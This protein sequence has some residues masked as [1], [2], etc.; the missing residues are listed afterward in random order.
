MLWNIRTEP[1]RISP[2]R[3]S[4]TCGPCAFSVVDGS[5]RIMVWRMS[6]GDQS[7]SLAGDVPGDDPVLEA[8]CL[9]RR[10]PL[11]IPARTYGFHWSGVAG[12][13]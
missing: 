13:T 8:R 4:C 12:S 1:F 6:S 11:Q 2:V 9:E 5:Q 10:L 3:G 7:G